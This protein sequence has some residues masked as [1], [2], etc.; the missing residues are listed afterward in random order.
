M[1]QTGSPWLMSMSAARSTGA[2]TSARSRPTVPVAYA[3]RS[4]A[5]VA[6]GRLAGRRQRADREDAEMSGKRPRLPRFDGIAEAAR[7]IGETF[8]DTSPVGKVKLPRWRARYPE[9]KVY[10][11]NT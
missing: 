5:R 6:Y 8:P 9:G 11:V 2:R 3:E 7:S 4:Q 10:V 1:R